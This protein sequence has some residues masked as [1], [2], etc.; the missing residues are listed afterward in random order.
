MERTRK[1]QSMKLIALSLLACP[2]IRGQA[3]AIKRSSV[4]AIVISLKSVS[5]ALHTCRSNYDREAAGSTIPFLQ[6]ALGKDFYSSAIS[7]IEQGQDIVDSMIK[8]PKGISGSML[9]FAVGS[10]F[11]SRI[12]TI[13]ITNELIIRTDKPDVDKAIFNIPDMTAAFS[14][15]HECQ[16]ALIAA[17]DLDDLAIRTVSAD[18]DELFHLRL[19]TIK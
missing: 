12:S 19:T 15:L 5:R 10:S 3:P 1:T 17:D 7:N 16:V 9:S 11:K 8:E 6:L 18:E 14:G 13:M 2:M 4:D